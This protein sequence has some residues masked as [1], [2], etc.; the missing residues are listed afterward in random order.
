MSCSARG[1][2]KMHN[3]VS[4]AQGAAGSSWRMDG[5]QTSLERKREQIGLCKTVKVERRCGFKGYQGDKMDR[6][7]PR[8]QRDPRVKDLP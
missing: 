3:Q 8:L 6:P 4:S 7:G 5:G 2:R 1:H